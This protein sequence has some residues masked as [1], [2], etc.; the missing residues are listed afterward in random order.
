MPQETPHSGLTISITTTSF[1]ASLDEL[2]IGCPKSPPVVLFT[3]AGASVPLGMP[4]MK[5][6]RRQFSEKLTSN[7]KLQWD[8]V[9][10]FSAKYYQEELADVDV[11]HVLTYIESC[12]FSHSKLVKLWKSTARRDEWDQLPTVRELDGFRSLLWTLRMR[13]LDE[14]CASYG[15]PDPSKTVKCYS[16]LLKM[17]AKTSGQ[18]SI[19]VFTT[20]YD[21][22]FEVLAEADPNQFEVFDG[23][24]SDPS[25]EETWK[26]VYIGSKQ[27]EHSITL[28]KLHG[29]TSWKGIP[30]RG[31]LRKSPPSTYLQGDE[32]TIIIYPTKSKAETQRL[33][34]RPFNQA[35]GSLGSL[36]A[37]PGAVG[38]LLVIG[39]GFGDEEIRRDIEEGL[40][41]EDTAKLIVVDPEATICRLSEDFPRVNTDR[42]TVIDSF[43]GQ[44]DTVA[45]IQSVLEEQL[46]E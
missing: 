25:G 17:L 28:W 2:G 37:Q 5:D 26:G 19:N 30:A 45:R 4:T 20:N 32:E 40:I 8:G 21:L 33:F 41:L 23:F 13:I 14:I 35:Y 39:Y 42:I 27:A 34:A 15:K 24:Y 29:S 7:L 22:T 36:F 43:F 16:P 44:D 12:L 46:D 9:E 1:Q 18:S 11:E 38:V 6:F 10:E 31:Q 3:G